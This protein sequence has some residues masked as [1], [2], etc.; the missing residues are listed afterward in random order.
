MA[1]IVC[2]PVTQFCAK[3]SN[4]SA[5]LRWKQTL[6]LSSPQSSRSRRCNWRGS[7]ENAQEAKSTKPTNDEEQK[8]QQKMATE[9][10]NGSTTSAESNVLSTPTTSE[11]S[12][13]FRGHV[14]ATLVWVGIAAA[15]TPLIGWTRGWEEAL[16]FVTAYVVEYSLSVDNLFV[17]LLIFNYFRVPEN[18]Q[19]RVLRWGII[20]AMAMRG[21]LITAGAELTRR[22]EF[23]TLIFAGI[24]LFSAG[25]LLLGDDDDDE[26][27]LSDN[28]IVKFA[29]SLVD[30]TTK[31]DGEKFFT[32]DNGV[33]MA[34]PLILVL[35][36]I[37]LSDIVFALDSVPAVLGISDDTIVIY[38]SN[39][40]AIQGLRNLF[41]ILSDSIG[42]LRFLS[43][44][45]AVVLGFVGF[46]MIAGVGGVHVPILPSLGVIV[47]TLGAGVGLSVAFPEPDKAA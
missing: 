43:K 6:S 18:S 8:K 24:L 16:E 37:E 11:R 30:V 9:E 28:S 17:F 5:G 7:I 25:K 41:F 39:V 4:S 38:L 44:S 29:R 46:K 33:R 22:F 10:L 3:H 21:V 19:E 26:G 1:F 15:C 45:L 13:A 2:A 47:G 12:E 32:V 23:M 34:T 20:G 42:D 14:R 36:C 27:N 35:L 40:L 31:F